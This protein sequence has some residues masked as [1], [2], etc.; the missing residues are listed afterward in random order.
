M[1][2]RIQTVALQ[3]R[4]R[5]TLLAGL[6][7]A[8]AAP[9]S[10]ADEAVVTWSGDVKPLLERRCTSCH[11]GWFPSAGLDLSELDDV[12]EGGRSGPL[13][14]AGQPDKGWLMQVVNRSSGRLRM[15]PSGPRLSEDDKMLLQRW[16]EQGLQP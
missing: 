11:S 15:P 8:L 13:V 9:A 16:I 14:V 6:L 7:C 2:S 3:S 10:A 12:L 4:S 5:T 1:N